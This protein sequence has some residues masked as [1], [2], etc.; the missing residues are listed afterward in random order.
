MDASVVADFVHA[1]SF[2]HVT[3]QLVSSSRTETVNSYQ[4]SNKSQVKNEQFVTQLNGTHLAHMGVMFFTSFNKDWVA[5]LLSQQ[6][7]SFHTVSELI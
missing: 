2:A 4:M 1:L 5:F 7:L 6:K 3:G